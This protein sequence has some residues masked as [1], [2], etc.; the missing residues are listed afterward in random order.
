MT[1]SEFIKMLQEADPKGTAHIRMEGGVPY[2]AELKAGYW[3]GPY[4]YID[5]DDN[6]VYS[7]SGSKVD[8]HCLGIWD[9]VEGRIG[10]K[11]TFEDI[12]HKFKFE[13]SVYATDEQRNERMERV[14]KEAKEAFDELR[15]MDNDMYERQLNEAIKEAEIGK[16]WFQNKEVDSVPEEEMNYH[17]YYTWKFIDEKGTLDSSSTPYRTQ[18]IL[19]SGLWE[20]LDN[21]AMEGYYEWIYKNK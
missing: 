7:A 16:R 8:I 19:R 14:L 17:F 11:S 15:K 1:T 9:Y 6:W 4:S 20:K 18:P 13:L 2:V 12:K 10:H 5:E 3:D 21:G